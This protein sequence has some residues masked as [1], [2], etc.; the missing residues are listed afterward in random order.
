[1]TM[2]RNLV[3]SRVPRDRGRVFRAA[4]PCFMALALAALMCGCGK[5]QKPAEEKPPV[6]RTQDAAYT[7]ALRKVQV[8]RNVIAS[9]R[10]EVVEQM[11]KLVARARKALPEGATD[12]QVRNE[13]LNNPRKYPGWNELSRMLR[14]HNASAENELKDARRLVM[15]RIMQEQKDFSKRGGSK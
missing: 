9:R 14:E 10:R 8:K 13:L 2:S 15:A 4:L 1:M 6:P 12:E 11:E 7:N 5:E 3:V